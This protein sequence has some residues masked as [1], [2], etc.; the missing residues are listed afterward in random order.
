[1]DSDDYILPLVKDNTVTDTDMLID[2]I[3]EL[4]LKV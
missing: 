4:S 3:K 2:Y 1:M